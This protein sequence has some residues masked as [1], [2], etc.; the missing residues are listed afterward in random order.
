M[1]DMNSYQLE[2]KTMDEDFLNGKTVNC[3]AVIPVSGYESG[4]LKEG[5]RIVV[6]LSIGK[7]FM[8][9]I[10]RSSFEKRGNLT[11]GKLEIIRYTKG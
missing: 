10:M 1:A 7:K 9:K 3:N 11:E 4:M 8:G 2:N 5:E 6:L